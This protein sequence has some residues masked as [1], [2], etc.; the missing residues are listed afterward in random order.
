M[1]HFL[2]GEIKMI[3]I[4]V[5][6]VVFFFAYLVWGVSQTY[7]EP[8]SKQFKIS[9]IQESNPEL[10]GSYFLTRE[11]NA[12]KWDDWDN[13]TLNDFL[14]YRLKGG[15]KVCLGWNAHNITFRAQS[16]FEWVVQDRNAII[17]CY[18]L[19]KK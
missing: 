7:S 10:I 9:H 6:A 8:T 17:P 14:L 18:I 4:V 15:P 11:N 16:G 1:A 5:V 13:I 12:Q 2:I 19:T 3:K